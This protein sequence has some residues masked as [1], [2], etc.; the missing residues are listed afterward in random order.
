MKAS[1]A[2]EI[3]VQISRV[4]KGGLRRGL[5]VEHTKETRGYLKF[6]KKHLFIIEISLPHPSFGRGTKCRGTKASRA[7]TV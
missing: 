7:P 2:R 3:G 4:V 6:S 5:N 1:R